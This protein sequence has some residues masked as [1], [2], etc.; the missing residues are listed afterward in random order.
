MQRTGGHKPHTAYREEAAD[1]TPCTPLSFKAKA[2]HMLCDGSFQGGG[3]GTE[4]TLLSCTQCRCLCPANS[5]EGGGA[6]IARRQG[7]A[8]A[9]WLISSLPGPF[10]SC[11]GS[12]SSCLVTTTPT[13]CLIGIA[14]VTIFDGVYT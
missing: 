2:V 7:L 8:S 5:A 9:Q 10:D 4:I 14:Y 12:Y 13:T 1:E 3:E 11:R 6:C